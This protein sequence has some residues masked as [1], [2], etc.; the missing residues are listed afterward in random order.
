[1]EADG[2]IISSYSLLLMERCVA[3]LLALMYSCHCTCI[4]PSFRRALKSFCVTTK[5]K[6]NTKKICINYYIVYV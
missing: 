4:W 2:C 3:V 5:K 6:K 1:M